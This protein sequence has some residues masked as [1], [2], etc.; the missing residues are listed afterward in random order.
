MV[1]L[2]EQSKRKGGQ[3]GR[4]GVYPHK[5]GYKRPPFSK[6]WRKRMRM[7]KIGKKLPL[8]QRIKIGNSHKGDKHWNWM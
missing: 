4:S 8:S 5:K 3:K 2:K 1:G 6:E 7:A